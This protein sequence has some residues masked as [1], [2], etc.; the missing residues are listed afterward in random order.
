MKKTLIL[1]AVLSGVAFSLPAF[2]ADDIVSSETETKTKEEKDVSGNYHA[3]RK[4]YQ[5]NTD[6]NGTL[7]STETTVKEKA[8]VNGDSEKMATTETVNDPKGLGNKT[9][10]V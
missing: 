6:A 3:K 1:C 10:T 4:A 2:A 5:E 9:K 7:N 8:N